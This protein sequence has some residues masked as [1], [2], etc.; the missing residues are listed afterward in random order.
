MFVAAGLVAVLAGAFLMVFLSQYRA[1]VTDGTLVNVAVAK[2]LIEKGSSGDVIVDKGLFEIQQIRKSQL[3]S[4][5]VTNPATLRGKVATDD[6]FP[7]DQMTGSDFKVG[8]DSIA[9]KITGFER[10]V[11]IPLDSA[12][13][14]IGEIGT[15][16]HVDVLAGFT[17][18][19]AY[20]G[21]PAL[22][23]ILQNALVLKAPS[24]VK[25]RGASVNKTQ[26][27]VIRATDK[28]AA[29]IAYAVD[30]GKVWLTL[31]PKAG[32]ESSPPSTVALETLV[33]GTTPIPVRRGR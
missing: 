21:R 5:A 7:G 29:Q 8:T 25:T 2:S 28:K 17:V 20:R 12:H 9:G 23:T 11:S 22:R 18:Q 32:A 27:V 3:D 30:N 19:G 15:G 16:D 10:A 13:G 31:R 4:G 14:S 33:A 6:I 24:E 26:N 1:R